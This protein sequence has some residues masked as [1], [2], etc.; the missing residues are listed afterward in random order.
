MPFLRTSL[1]AFA[2]LALAGCSP[3][4]EPEAPETQPEAATPFP[5]LTGELPAIVAHRGASG[6]LPEHTEAAFQLAFDQGADILEPD[7]MVSRD[8]VLIVRHDPYLSTS[9]DVAD[10]PE[11]A[12]RRRELMGREDWWVIDF[13]AGE[14]QSLN[15]RQVFEDRPQEY[16]DQFPIMTFG[17][18]LDMVDAMQ[19][20]CNC[21]IPV[22]PE[23]KLPA[24]HAAMGLDPLPILIAELEA[25]GLNTEDSL[26]II[27]SFD[28]PFLERLRPLTPL[29]LAMLHY[30][31]APGGD[32]NGYSLEQVAE[33]A[34]AIGPYKGLLLN[35]DGSSTGYVERAHAL[36]LVV[37]AW[38]HRDDRPSVIEGGTSDDEL[39][40][41]F[42]LGVDGVFTDFPDTA[43]RIRDDML[44]G[45]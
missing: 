21:D 6:Y 39:R 25:R 31:D 5:T 3:A 37:H 19:A 28:A 11:F 26:V 38:T 42:A 33:F 10:R 36:G 43:V 29:P 9:S 2:A 23:I 32:M 16:N 17:D 15:A 8:G 30:G 34:D 20:R 24:E 4:S 44:R 27:Q 18:F 40:A 7:L 41:L 1:A 14:L 12:D 13:T 22:E 35:P 45:E